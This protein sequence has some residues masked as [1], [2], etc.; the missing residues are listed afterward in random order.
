MRPVGLPDHASEVQQAVGVQNG[1][2]AAGLEKYAPKGY[3]NYLIRPTLGMEKPQY[4]RAKLQ[5]Q[6]RK[7]KGQV[8]AGLYAQNSHYLVELRDCLVRIRSFRKSLTM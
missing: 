7:F 6:T 5:F 4:Y 1:L 3:E 2:A 8:K